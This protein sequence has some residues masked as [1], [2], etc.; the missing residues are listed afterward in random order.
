M[1]KIIIV[2]ILLSITIIGFSQ[3]DNPTTN[4]TVEVVDAVFDKTTEAVQGLALALKVPA[5]HVYSILVKQQVIRAA[6]VLCCIV[7]C[8]ILGFILLKWS[9]NSWRTANINYNTENKRLLDSNDRYDIDDNWWIWPFVIGIVLLIIGVLISLF[10]SNVI[11]TGLFNPE[12]GAIKDI[13]N[14]IK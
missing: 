7:I 8:L 14:F 12:Y 6:T 11:M 5:E 2:L 4:K 9:I 10:G 1:K 3:P 13:T